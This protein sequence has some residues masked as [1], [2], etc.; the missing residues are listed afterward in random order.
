MTKNIKGITLLEIIIVVSIVSVLLVITIFNGIVIVRAKERNEL[1]EFK[2]D[3][4]YARDRSIIESKSYYVDIN[5]NKNM[6]SIR[7]SGNI[8][9]KTIKRKELCEGIKIQSTNISGNEVVFYSSGAPKFAGTIYMEDSRGQKIKLTVSPATGKIN[10]Y[11][12]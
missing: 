7:T 10:I 1:K 2:N 5:P 12:D 9:S 3:I 4:I 11:F 6:Y 8:S